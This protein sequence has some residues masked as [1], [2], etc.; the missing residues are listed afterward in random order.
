MW[1]DECGGVLTR[2]GQA[3]LGG[4]AGQQ[5]DPAAE[6]GDVRVEALH[7]V[8]GVVH[9]GG[10]K[11]TTAIGHL[12]VV[13]EHRGH[14]APS[15]P[16][17]RGAYLLD[18]LQALDDPDVVQVHATRRLPVLDGDAAL[19]RGQALQELQQV[20]VVVVDDAVWAGGAEGD[21]FVGGRAG[22]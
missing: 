15:P 19:R 11:Q 17:R 10:G 13:P 8:A 20:G 5:L 3:V 22:G 4:G 18:V 2:L 16:R 7:L 1:D 14:H 9:L 6:E 21:C 12:T